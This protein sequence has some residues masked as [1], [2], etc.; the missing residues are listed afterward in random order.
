MRQNDRNGEADGRQ[1]RP[2]PPLLT[3][4][5]PAG[6]R[7]FGTLAREMIPER[8][9]N[10]KREAGPD[11]GT[12]IERHPGNLVL[13]VSE[14]VRHDPPCAHVTETLERSQKLAAIGY[15]GP[16]SAQVHRDVDG[17]EKRQI[18]RNPD[19]RHGEDHANQAIEL[20]QQ[21]AKANPNYE[22]GGGPYQ[23]FDGV[24]RTV[25]WSAT[26]Y[27]EKHSAMRINGTITNAAFKLV[28][29]PVIVPSRCR[30]IAHC[31][32]KQISATVATDRPTTMLDSQVSNKQ[33]R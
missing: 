28:S 14:V 30:I 32:A 22:E 8:G 11:R 7:Y 23:I 17:H 15:P 27:H 1:T 10:T 26:A 18:A 2:A 19:D 4:R 33:I 20:R 13:P 5:R 16:P 6:G 9:E 3:V 12:E 24:A 31:T 29:D 21:P 25:G